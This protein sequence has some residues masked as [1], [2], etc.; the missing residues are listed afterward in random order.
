MPPIFQ[1]LLRNLFRPPDHHGSI[2]RD[3][4]APRSSSTVLRDLYSTNK[5][6]RK[7]ETQVDHE[8]EKPLPELPPLSIP[9]DYVWRVAP[10]T[11]GG[12]G[13][14]FAIKGRCHSE[15]FIL[16]TVELDRGP[17]GI[18]AP[19]MEIVA[20]RRIGR[21]G[22]VNLIEQPKLG[23]N[24]ETEWWSREA[25]L[26]SILFN[27]YP[28]DLQDVIT[29]TKRPS[30]KARFRAVVREVDFVKLVISDVM[31]G[32]AHLHSLR[33][34]HRDLKPENIFIDQHGYCKIGD[35][36]SAF[37]PVRSSDRPMC[38]RTTFTGGF[39]FRYAAPELVASY[40]DDVDQLTWCYDERVDFWALGLIILDLLRVEVGSLYPGSWYALVCPPTEFVREVH[41]TFDKKYCLKDKKTAE[42]FKRCIQ[43][44]PNGRLDG[45]AGVQLVKDFHF[46]RTGFASFIHDTNW[47]IHKSQRMLSEKFL[48]PTVALN[49]H[50]LLGEPVDCPS[51]ERMTTFDDVLHKMNVKL[52]ERPQ[53]RLA[54]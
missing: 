47:F 51:E 22:H 44:Y 50:P 14:I 49:S 20:L 1:K 41:K 7:A 18:W 17:G 8:Q 16:K 27:Y 36:G 24:V 42:I 13:R 25:G 5:P 46:H 4:G 38:L 11:R 2:R 6:C 3:E 12:F 33:I 43:A 19:A 23:K 32:L 40:S 45:D 30:S 54:L 15:R 10:F 26:L 34:I 28:V 31:H 37:I 52:E 39:T 21:N 53:Y 48:R 35:F 9:P 29:I